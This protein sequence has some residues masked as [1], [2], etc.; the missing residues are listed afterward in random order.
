M[1]GPGRDSN[2]KTP[3]FR[4]EALDV[5]VEALR[6]WLREK[7][8]ERAGGAPR[9]VPLAPQFCEEFCHQQRTPSDSGIG[10]RQLTAAVVADAC[11][12][13]KELRDNPCFH[14]TAPVRMADGSFKSVEDL[15]AGDAV[16]PAAAGARAPRVRCVAPA[17]AGA[18]APRVRCVVK[19]D[20]RDGKEQ[21]VALNGGKLLITPWHP[22]LQGDQWGFPAKVAPPQETA[23]THV[24]SVVLDGGHSLEVGGVVCVTLGHGLVSDAVTNHPY[25]ATERVLQDLKRMPGFSSGLLHFQHGGIRRG[26]DGRVIGFDE[27]RLYSAG[28]NTQPSTGEPDEDIE[29]FIRS[30]KLE[31]QIAA[32]FFAGTTLADVVAM[33]PA[34]TAEVLRKAMPALQQ[35]L[36]RAQV[37]ARQVLRDRRFVTQSGRR[38]RREVREGFQHRFRAMRH[39]DRCCVRHM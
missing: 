24:Y 19:T 11:D 1:R 36:E 12:R 30:L 32:L 22:V 18:R 7:A 16:A 35:P 15:R 33:E 37:K 31:R 3:P 39:Q 28:G 8:A 26:D 2:P 20:C 34:E 13:A 25:F 27:S 9:P 6:A 21:M 23:C 17:A 10:E 4:K 14:H 29:R 5:I 38:G